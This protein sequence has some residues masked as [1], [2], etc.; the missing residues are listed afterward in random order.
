MVN[1]GE[2]DVNSDAS[3]V[4]RCQGANGT[5]GT[6]LPIP[7]S[8]GRQ[9][10]ST[11]PTSFPQQRDRV[12]PNGL[13]RRDETRGNRDDEQNGPRGQEGRGIGGLDAEQQT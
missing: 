3:D 12:D 4:P 8:D 10:K 6:W 11:A 7:P 2:W 5:E 13:T 9:G 1:Q